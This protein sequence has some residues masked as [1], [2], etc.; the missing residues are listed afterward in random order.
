MDAISFE[1]ENVPNHLVSKLE[2]GNLVKPGSKSLK[3]AQNRIEE[4]TFLS[5]NTF[6]VTSHE[7]VL[8]VEEF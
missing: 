3:L 7:F 1:R 6:P 5:S 2:N 4:K 8:N